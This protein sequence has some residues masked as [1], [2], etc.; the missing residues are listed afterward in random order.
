MVLRCNLD[1]P[2]LHFGWKGTGTGVKDICNNSNIFQQYL[3]KT[4]SFK[5]FKNFKNIYLYIH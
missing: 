5:Q 1:E 4:D 3:K 2:D